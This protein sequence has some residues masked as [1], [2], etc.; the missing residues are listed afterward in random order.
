N[1]ESFTHFC[2][3][4][5]QRTGGGKNGFYKLLLLCRRPKFCRT[6]KLAAD[7]NPIM[8]FTLRYTVRRSLG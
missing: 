5:L 1:K 4:K 2:C 7:G 8:S 3:A 6:A